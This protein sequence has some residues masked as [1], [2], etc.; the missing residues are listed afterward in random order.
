MLVEKNRKYENNLVTVTGHL[1]TPTLLCSPPLRNWLVLFLYTC[2]TSNKAY[3]YIYLYKYLYNF[4][5]F[6]SG[7]IGLKF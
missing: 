5:L 7:S 4:N 1:G 2:I 3:M 6:K